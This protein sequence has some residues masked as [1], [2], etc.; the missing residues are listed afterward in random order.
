MNN[1]FVT[2]R[3]SYRYITTLYFEISIAEHTQPVLQLERLTDGWV[4]V[5]INCH[6]EQEAHWKSVIADSPKPN[7]MDRFLAFLR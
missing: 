1:V 3:V 5:S 2:G 7:L 6:P 4:G